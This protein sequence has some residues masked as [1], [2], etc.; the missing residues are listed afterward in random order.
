MSTPAPADAAW[1]ADVRAAV[2]SY[3]DAN[4]L[5]WVRKEHDTMAA[6]GQAIRA[7]LT[8]H[9][10]AIAKEF[11]AV[12]RHASALR[13]WA[14]FVRSITTGDSQY[15]AR[16][17]GQIAQVERLQQAFAVWHEDLKRTR[18]LAPRRLRAG[19]QKGLA[20]VGF[21]YPV[22]RRHPRVSRPAI[23]RCAVA[24]LRAHEDYL[25]DVDRQRVTAFAREFG[26]MSDTR[27]TDL[28]VER[29]I[30]FSKQARRTT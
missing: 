24:A 16:V 17:E 26:E 19:R 20:L 5:E 11:V 27:A 7:T 9:A 25:L 13:D 23:A 22:Q 29:M 2:T 14:E 6:G 1:Q 8:R 12:T 10:E 18:G 28:L 30:T 3:W 21:L 15:V 4:L